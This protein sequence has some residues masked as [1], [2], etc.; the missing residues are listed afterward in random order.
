MLLLYFSRAT[1]WKDNR[2]GTSSSRVEVRPTNASDNSWMAA[3][4]RTRW[5]SDRIVSRERL[6]YPDRLSGF[7]AYL[8]GSPVGLA[9]YN[10]EGRE[11]E[12]VTLD[13][14]VEGRGV[15]S[16]LLEAV[17]KLAIARGCRRVW[18][19]TTND[20]TRALRFYQRF[21]FRLVA[22]YPD[23]LEKSRLL[24]PEIPSIGMDGIPLRDEIELEIRLREAE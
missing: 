21:G 1:L 2:M 5:K 7:V 11:C 24:K 10:I 3:Y 16:S 15:G 8:D 13:S 22:L 23:Q 18:F 14:D 19:I 17:K 20:N 12:L 6:H 4:I 9:T